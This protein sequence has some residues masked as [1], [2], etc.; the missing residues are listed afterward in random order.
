MSSFFPQ[1]TGNERISKLINLY[2]IANANKCDFYFHIIST[3][4][5]IN[6]FICF[7]LLAQNQNLNYKYKSNLLPI[8]IH[9]IHIITGCLSSKFNT[10]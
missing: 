9:D 3:V 2:A 8:Y 7:S 6:I 1:S 4:Y 5:T 10:L